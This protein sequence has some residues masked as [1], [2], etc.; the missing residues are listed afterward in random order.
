MLSAEQKTELESIFFRK[1]KR[2]SR[3]YDKTAL[4]EGV[5]FLGILP[6]AER[7]LPQLA[8]AC[9]REQLWERMAFRV[10]PKVQI[11]DMGRKR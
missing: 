2:G 11:T 7:A 8:K 5:D 6:R 3:A 10:V 4:S 1:H 9:T